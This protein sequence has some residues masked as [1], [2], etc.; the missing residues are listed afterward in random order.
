MYYKDS[1]C[2]QMV[3]SLVGIYLRTCSKKKKVNVS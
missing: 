3:Y 2:Y 1:A